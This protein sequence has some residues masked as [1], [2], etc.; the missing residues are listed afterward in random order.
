MTYAEEGVKLKMP[1]IPKM[2]PK[3]LAISIGVL[4]VI[5]GIWIGPRR[6]LSLRSIVGGVVAF[7]GAVVFAWGVRYEDL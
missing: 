2:F 5:I 3:W 4:L 6:N 7:S 1:H